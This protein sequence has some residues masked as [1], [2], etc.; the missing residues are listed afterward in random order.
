MFSV[1]FF[2]NF[3][4]LPE[5]IKGTCSGTCF[6]FSKKLAWRSPG[7]F[8]DVFEGIFLK[9]LKKLLCSFRR[10]FPKLSEKHLLSSFRNFP[11]VLSKVLGG[12][13]LMFSEEIHRN[14]RNIYEFSK[15]SED[16]SWFSPSRLLSAFDAVVLNAWNNNGSTNWLSLSQNSEMYFKKLKV[17]F[18]FAP[19]FS[20]WNVR[21]QWKRK[22]TCHPSRS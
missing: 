9:L 10:N 5:V 8:R 19:H 12:T 2:W 21:R 20:M 13:F 6:E 17:T 11:N 3:P 1:K 16:F 4:N 22:K 14:C 15:L 7:N 18:V